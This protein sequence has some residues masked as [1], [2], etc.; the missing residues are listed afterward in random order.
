MKAPEKLKKLRTEK[1]ESRQDTADAI[2][3]SASSICQY[4]LGDKTPR[5]EVK[6]KLAEHFGVSVQDLFFTP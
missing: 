2:G 3:V 6:V 4:E 1:G 5:D